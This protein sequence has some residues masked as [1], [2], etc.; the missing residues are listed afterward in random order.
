MA[1]NFLASRPGMMP[2]Q[3][4][5]TQVQS[6]SAAAQSALPMSMSKPWRSPFSSIQLK[7][8]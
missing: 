2:S 8:G 4:W 6:S 5:I 1:S 3:S 7:G